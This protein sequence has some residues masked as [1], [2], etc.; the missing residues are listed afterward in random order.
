MP[1][2]IEKYCDEVDLLDEEA[3]DKRL[4]IKAK[5]ISE[6]IVRRGRLRAIN[7]LRLSGA[8]GENVLTELSYAP[9]EEDYSSEVS[10]L[11]LLKRCGCRDLV[12]RVRK[13]LIIRML[14]DN[15]EERFSASTKGKLGDPEKFF[16][17]KYKNLFK[18]LSLPKQY[19]MKKIDPNLY[20]Y[21]YKKTNQ[22]THAIQE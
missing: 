19:A 4:S 1:L 8:V 2:E 11:L 9:I 22:K 17:A 3:I 5:E 6:L 14:H 18:K 12:E 16:N 10:K 13:D 21:F 20:T 7:G 15:C